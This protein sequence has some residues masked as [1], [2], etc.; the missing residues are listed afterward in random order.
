MTCPYSMGNGN[1]SS[2]FTINQ[3]I[4][5]CT[6]PSQYEGNQCQYCK[7]KNKRNKIFSN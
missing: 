5:Q 1:C 7:S 4:N 6:C 2:V 3:T